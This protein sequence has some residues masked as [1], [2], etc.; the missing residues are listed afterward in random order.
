[1]DS[2]K[3]EDNHFLVDMRIRVPYWIRGICIHK[4]LQEVFLL[5]PFLHFRP[6]LRDNFV[7]YRVDFPAWR[8]YKWQNS[9]KWDQRC[10]KNSEQISVKDSLLICIIRLNKVERATKGGGTHDILLHLAEAIK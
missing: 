2:H 8:G 5:D 6:T 3:H 7:N 9:M 4:Y 10:C 1:M